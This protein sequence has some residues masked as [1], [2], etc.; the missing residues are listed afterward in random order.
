MIKPLLVWECVSVCVCVCACARTR[1]KFSGC[2]TEYQLK[3]HFKVSLPKAD[4]QPTNIQEHE[5]V[6]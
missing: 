6:E 5:F 3:M 2:N 1:I 4:S